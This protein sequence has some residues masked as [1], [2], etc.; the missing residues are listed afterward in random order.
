METRVGVQYKENGEEVVP[1]GHVPIDTVLVVQDGMLG[2]RSVFNQPTTK[3]EEV[4]E[5]GEIS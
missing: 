1:E 4:K 5:H 2:H 3:V